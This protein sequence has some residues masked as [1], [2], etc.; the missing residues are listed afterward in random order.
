MGS[1]REGLL[2]AA[3]PGGGGAASEGPLR[4]E[5]SLCAA[6]LAI[7]VSAVGVQLCCLGRL[8]WWRGRVPRPGAGERATEDVAWEDLRGV[9]LYLQ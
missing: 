8:V 4:G 1:P 5:C 7:A 6:L 9:L 2:R 3:S